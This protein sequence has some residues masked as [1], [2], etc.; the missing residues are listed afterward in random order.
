M[1]KNGDLILD[2]R[3]MATFWSL[4]LNGTADLAEMFA[5]G[6][7]AEHLDKTKYASYTGSQNMVLTRGPES[8]EQDSPHCPEKV[9]NA[10]TDP[11]AA[12]LMADDVAG[13]PRTFLLTAQFDVLCSEGLLYKQRLEEAGVDVTHRMFQS[14]HGF[15]S[16]P[17]LTD[18]ASRAF[19]E[20]VE[21]LKQFSKKHRK[22]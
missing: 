18:E 2:R 22:P 8:E 15:F 10:L 12:P 13:L 19:G 4:Y 16:K 17:D 5:A 7:H 20:T 1:R 3:Q 6:F 9:L 14:F 11:R 21:F